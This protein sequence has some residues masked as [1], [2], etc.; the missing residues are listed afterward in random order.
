MIQPWIELLLIIFVTWLPAGLIGAILIKKMDQFLGHI[1]NDPKW[2][3]EFALFGLGT[4]LIGVIM[5]IAGHLFHLVEM[6]LDQIRVR[7][8]GL[9]KQF[10][11]LLETTDVF[12][13]RF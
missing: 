8:K 7:S 10:N 5:V 4:L 1:H 12:V 6:L 9:R 13:R 11:N 3:G 2:Y